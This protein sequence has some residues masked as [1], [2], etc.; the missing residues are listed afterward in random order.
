[1]IHNESR[2]DYK[3]FQQPESISNSDNNHV[4]SSGNMCVIK[5]EAPPIE[6][7]GNVEMED[8]SVEVVKKKK[9]INGDAVPTMVSSNDT[10]KLL[11]DEINS[12]KRKLDIQ[13]ELFSNL[14]KNYMVT[15]EKN[16]E[17]EQKVKELTEKTSCSSGNNNL[18]KKSQSRYWTK[19]E[20]EKFLEALKLF[21]KKDVKS[22]ANYVGSR[23]PTQVRTHAQKWFLKQKRETERKSSKDKD[24][25]PK[26]EPQV[27]TQWKQVIRPNTGITTS[28][29]PQPLQQ[30]PRNTHSNRDHYSSQ[31]D[32]KNVIMSRSPVNIKPYVNART[33]PPRDHSNGGYYPN[34][35][36][37]H[38]SV[39]HRMHMDMKR[40][41]HSPNMC[42]SYHEPKGRERIYSFHYP[43]SF[44]YT[45][46]VDSNSL[47][48]MANLIVDNKSQNHIHNNQFMHMDRHISHRNLIP[49]D[50]DEELTKI[51]T[52][53]KTKKSHVLSDVIGGP[54]SIS[55]QLY[56][57]PSPMYPSSISP[58]YFDSLSPLDKNKR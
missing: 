35:Y 38:Y 44:Q 5:E 22:I 13:Q 8:L 7:D 50:D 21:G 18:T 47:Q 39:N 28:P 58:N 42:D 37:N 19:E 48:N 57:T 26:E 40:E 45:S 46:Q 27:Q 51:T 12:L 20:H 14:Q 15:V 49:D 4:S 9:S 1:M 52:P 23:N 31:I 32:S 10:V 36:D 41:S 56:S 33:P 34:S 16:V 25:T 2:Q 3:D 53:Q 54:V 6:K 43:N 30:S 24:I 55:P 11:Y 17:L 29:P